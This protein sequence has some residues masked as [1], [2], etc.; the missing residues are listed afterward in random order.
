L[1]LARLN[2]KQAMFRPNVSRNVFITNAMEDF[3]LVL[4]IFERN[5]DKLADE[6]NN[7]RLLWADLATS[8]LA[9]LNL[10]ASA[11]GDEE[12]AENEHN[13]LKKIQIFLFIFIFDGKKFQTGKNVKKQ[14]KL[15]NLTFFWPIS[16]ISSNF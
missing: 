14:A 5:S 3:G 11:A 10:P 8:S 6:W 13:A 2:Q 16:S 15:E 12:S 1:D 7:G 9:G 4:T